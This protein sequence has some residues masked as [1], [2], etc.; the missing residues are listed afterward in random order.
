VKGWK[1]IDRANG[2]LK[3]AGAAILISH[4]VDFKL[5]LVKRDKE[6]HFILI[7]GANTPKGN[8][9]YQPIFTKSVHPISS[10]IH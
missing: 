5:T 1:N 10:K 8:N 4:K 6:G 9:N 3:Q 2:P 7:K